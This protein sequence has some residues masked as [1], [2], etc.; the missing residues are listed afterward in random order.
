M[1]S[2]P[3]LWEFLLITRFGEDPIHISSLNSTALQALYVK[4]S[5]TTV[6][7]VQIGVGKTSQAV[8][9]PFGRCTN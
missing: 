9:S 4:K 6:P 3:A 5:R 7:A 1:V 2:R 8:S